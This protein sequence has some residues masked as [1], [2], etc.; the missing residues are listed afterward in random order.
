MLT[1][2]YA[3]RAKTIRNRAPSLL[4]EFDLQAESSS[5]ATIMA[6]QKRLL[7][8]RERHIRGL[9]QQQRE[10]SAKLA[11]M[12]SLEIAAAEEHEAQ[13][14]HGGA[15]SKLNAAFER[16]QKSRNLYLGQQSR[17]QSWARA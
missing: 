4:S 11:S 13:R 15:M 8:E 10:L 17:R 9:Q 1:L 14:A 6:A 7:A 2:D 16:A 12:Q 3:A 5:S